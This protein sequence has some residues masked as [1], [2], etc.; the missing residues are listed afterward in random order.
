P[1]KGMFM[2]WRALFSLLFFIAS[3]ATLAAKHQKKD[4]IF[5]YVVI[6]SYN[7]EKWCI[8]NIESIVKQDYP[9]WKAIYINDLSSDRTG[10]IV[11]DYLN[12]H[13]HLRQKFEVVH[14]QKRKGMLA[15]IYNAVK[16]AKK[17][18]VV[19]TVDG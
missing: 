4:P 1:K 16:K 19:V 13:S 17:N 15:N 6:P 9:H 5:F 8:R 14:N 7:N 3:S 10:N 2:K 18:W 11:E 12:Q